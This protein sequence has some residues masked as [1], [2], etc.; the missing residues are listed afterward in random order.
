MP[1]KNELSHQTQI[2]EN[3]KNK[4][5]STHNSHWKERVVTISSNKVISHERYLLKRK[6]QSPKLK[7]F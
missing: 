7:I 6:C 3:I 4:K 2:S 1:F 5:I